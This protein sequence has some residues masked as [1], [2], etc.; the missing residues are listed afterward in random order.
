MTRRETS[1]QPDWLLALLEEPRSD[2]DES[3][4]WHESDDRGV[5]LTDLQRAALR[6]ISSLD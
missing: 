2:Q 1:L 3:A 5:L 6:W 4:D